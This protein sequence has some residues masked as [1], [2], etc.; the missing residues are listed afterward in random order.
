MDNRNQF[1]REIEDVL[2]PQILAFPDMHF[3]LYDNQW[4]I[5]RQENINN[6]EVYYLTE[7][8]YDAAGVAKVKQRLANLENGCR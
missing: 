5:Y 2:R 3:D 6:A 7:G 1:R 4:H 8:N